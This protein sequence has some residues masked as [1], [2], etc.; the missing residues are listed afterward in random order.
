MEI[1]TNNSTKAN[2][3]IL[4]IVFFLSATI[5]LTDIFFKYYL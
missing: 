5:T 4:F 2:V 1:T 3:F